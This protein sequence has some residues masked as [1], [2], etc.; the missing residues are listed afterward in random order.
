MW[1]RDRGE[2]HPPEVAGAAINCYSSEK[3]GFGEGRNAELLH[4]PKI[5]F[6]CLVSCGRA[7][8][9]VSSYETQNVTAVKLWLS[10]VWEFH[11]VTLD[12]KQ[13]GHIW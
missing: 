9:P 11:W 13:P 1:F 4:D 12:L 2:V 5:S 10:T 7:W 6:M 8:L 3:V